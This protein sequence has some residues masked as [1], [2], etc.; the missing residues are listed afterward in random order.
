MKTRVLIAVVNL[1][2]L[3]AG[4]V[5]AAVAGCCLVF[6]LQAPA[7]ETPARSTR[8]ERPVVLTVALAAEPV[9]LDPHDARDG[10]SA[11]VNFHI[12][13]RLLET[14][15][16]G[17]LVPALATSWR[18]LPDGLTYVFTL[19]RGVVFHD[20][21]P[22]DA[23]AVVANFQRLLAG[24]PPPA[25]RELVSPY[26]DSVEALDPYTVAV[27]LTRPF[28]PFLRHLAH[29]SLAMVSPRSIRLAQAGSPF[30]PSGTGPF[31]LSDWTPGD[32]LTLVKH[33]SHWR[34]EPAVDVLEFRVIPD[35]SGRALALET[36]AVH[37]AYPLDPVHLV[38]LRRQGRVVVEQ[39]PG[40]RVVYAALNLARPPLDNAEFRRALNMAVDRE[41]IAQ[42]LLFGLAVP[43]D[44]PL[45]PATW[46]YA[47]AIRY[48]Y[49]PLAAKRLL[50][51]AGSE[52]RRPFELWSPSSRYLQDK[53]VAEAVAAYL[54]EAGLDVRIRLFEWGTY[55]GMLERSSAWDI[56]VLGWV[57]AT[58]DADMAL[59]PLY[60]S[61]TRGNHSGYA[62][63]AVD[64]L[65]DAAAFTQD[66]ERR[67]ALYREVQSLIAQD[68]PAIFLYA[69]D[70][71]YGRQP[72]LEGVVVHSNEI[73]DL[74]A[75][76][77]R[78]PAAGAGR[79]GAQD[80]TGGP[81]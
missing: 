76:R 61:G 23:G 64:R 13:D 73:I 5:I 52:A 72:E 7:Q 43:L 4:C 69:M 20:G 71:T 42:H 34:G 46:G 50:A 63:P 35:G 65:L 78:L 79:P 66:D 12:Y 47:P 15:P 49:D 56:A 75:A 1:R 80:G 62:S 51:A 17:E 27:R 37:L 22:F 9:R 2:R 70:V 26:V 30:H 48:T 10:P 45:A 55:L 54:E 16:G 8:Q 59:R 11:L 58:G 29:E 81:R 36:G 44:S 28:G 21:E 38:R 68:A 31:K 77:V 18:L 33:E 57:P 6:R 67:K 19:R 25:R 39:V 41:A 14:G 74:R 53:E 40:Q 32:R 60:Y 3:V 24:S